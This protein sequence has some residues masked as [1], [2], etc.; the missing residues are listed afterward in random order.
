[1]GFDGLRLLP[2]SRN[3]MGFDGFRLL[4]ASFYRKSRT[5]KGNTMALRV[6]TVIF[7]NLEL[8]KIVFVYFVYLDVS[9]K[10][11]SDSQ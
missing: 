9:P 3:A 5:L 11:A 4:P 8:Q 10:S 7:A 6:T 2:V 1:M